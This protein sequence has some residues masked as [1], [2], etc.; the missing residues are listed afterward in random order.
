MLG[1]G[2]SEVPGLYVAPG[3]STY[4]LKAGNEYSLGFGLSTYG[5]PTIVRQY[6]KGI[7]KVPKGY[8]PL[9]LKFLQEQL[10]DTFKIRK[11]YLKEISYAYETKGKG[12]FLSI[13]K[14][15]EIEATIFGGY[16]EL[17]AKKFYTILPSTETALTKETFFRRGALEV[18]G[19]R[20][21]KF[22][23]LKPSTYLDAATY[24]LGIKSK[25]FGLGYAPGQFKRFGFNK[26]EGLPIVIEQRTFLPEVL[27][28]P[29]T[30]GSVIEGTRETSFKETSTP[31]TK[32]Y[33]EGYRYYSTPSTLS[34]NM[35]ASMK[36]KTS[37]KESSYKPSSY[38]VSSYKISS[39]KPYSSKA[40]SSKLS[41]ITSSSYK[42]SSYKVSSYKLP[43]YKPSTS[44]SSGSSSTS[45][46]GTS[47][48]GSS[49]KSSGSYSSTY[50]P[51]YV[52]PI[53]KFK[54]PQIQRPISK[55]SK[56]K[57]TDRFKYKYTPTIE[58]AI[59]NIRS[60]KTNMREAKTGLFLRPILMES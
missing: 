39:Y 1:A 8:K 43:S 22:N 12:F 28:K 46:S 50:I 54:F 56:S 17:S 27:A 4:F 19:A 13:G 25:T 29:A 10:G 40:S 34:V 3:T 48:G 36:G 11:G 38:K 15:P 35:L 52:P 49:G 14:K 45:Y 33:L 60:K 30:F 57:R 26:L 55:K 16:S 53:Y 24:K 59:F 58:A 23:I 51:S 31:I 6:A 20:T 44:Y 32:E 2:T 21:Q 47:R 37:S 18:V 9:K 42:P 41:S 5:E 7:M